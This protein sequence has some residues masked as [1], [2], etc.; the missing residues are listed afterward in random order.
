MPTMKYN[1]MGLL[2]DA[3]MQLKRRDGGT[4][5]A[6]LELANN[7][8]LVMRGEASIED[9]KGGYTGHDD[10]AFDIDKILPT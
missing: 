6:I 5:Y 2:H 10:E 9:F 1:V 7:L 3:A 8:R 4:A